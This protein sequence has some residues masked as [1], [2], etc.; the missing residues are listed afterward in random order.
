MHHKYLINFLN[1]VFII[2]IGSANAEILKDPRTRNETISNT[3]LT[4]VVNKRADGMYEYLYNMESP[5]T[6]KGIINR[7]SIDLS[8]DLD[9]GPVVFTDPE[10]EFFKG[11]LS[12]DGK[13]VPFR[14]H[15]VYAMT[16]YSRISV[17][18]AISWG[19]AFAP[20][21]S[22]KGIKI[23]SPAPP[24]LRTYTLTPRMDPD[25]WDYSTYSS[26]DPSV[27]WI[28]DFA[29]TG[30]IKAPACTLK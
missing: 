7:F 4:V 20:G 21:D 14:S 2:M 6:N 1:F 12:K 28:S 9:F 5:L 23:V 19:M 16:T 13:F 29:V 15:G 26:D 22:G 18:N 11:S 24:G 27:P 10:D 8:C 30:S 25:E 3:L 17:D